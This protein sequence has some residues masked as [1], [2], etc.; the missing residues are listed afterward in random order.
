MQNPDNDNQTA[1]QRFSDKH[2][3]DRIK[4]HLTNEKDNISADDISNVQSNISSP[5]EE[6]KAVDDEKVIDNT[7]DDEYI[8]KDDDDKDKPKDITPWNVI[9]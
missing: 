4:E 5:A 7:K 2:T 9:D 6:N 3:D 8:G 1:P